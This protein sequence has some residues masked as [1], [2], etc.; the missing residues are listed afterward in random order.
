MKRKVAVV[1]GS[2]RGIGKQLIKL[3]AKDNYDVIITYNNSEKEAFDLRDYVIKKYN[4]NAL[5]I[6]CDITNE[7]QII[8]M[9]NTIIEKYNKIDLL[10]NNAAYASDNYIY[11][12]T[13]EEF[14]KVLEVNVVGTFLVTK[15]LY[16]YLNDGIIVNVSSTDAVN[17]YNSISMDYCASK[18]GVNSLTKTFSQEFKNIKVLGVMP[19]WTNTETVREMNK[20]Y[21]KAELKR[22]N[23]ERLYEPDEVADNI[24][25]IINDNSVI[26]GSILEV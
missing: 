16:P 23:Q 4:V 13:K 15:Y 3:L 2:A 1:T 21:L 26:S 11:D 7:K 20:E 9:K 6:K 8:N 24:I 14:M 5:A 10:I 22:V 18:A 12:K 17:T 25:K 19:R